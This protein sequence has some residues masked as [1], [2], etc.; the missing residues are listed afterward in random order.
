MAKVVIHFDENEHSIL[1]QLAER[2]YRTVTAQVALMIHQKLQELNLIPCDENLMGQ[3][4][5]DFR[6][7]TSLK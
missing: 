1:Q 7:E 5:T 3:S 6:T 4:T 2:E